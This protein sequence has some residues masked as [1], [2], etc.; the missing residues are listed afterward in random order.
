M[1][2]IYSIPH[3]QRRIGIRTFHDVQKFMF[4][5]YVMYV[6]I[7]M[8]ETYYLDG[9]QVYLNNTLTMFFRQSTPGNRMP[10]SYFQNMQV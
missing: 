2:H 1:D 10:L 7:N 5:S 8:Y 3:F 9:I 6:Y 4:Y